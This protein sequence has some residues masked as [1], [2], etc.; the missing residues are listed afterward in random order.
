MRKNAR[1]IDFQTNDFGT[2]GVLSFKL[3]SVALTNESGMYGLVLFLIFFLPS[4]RPFFVKE[5]KK[6][7]NVSIAFGI[8]LPE[9]F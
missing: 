5:G 4:G 9:K 1:I 8:I 7:L 3:T 2:R 6:R